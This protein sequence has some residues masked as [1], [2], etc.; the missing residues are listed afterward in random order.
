MKGGGGVAVAVAAVA[1]KR[2][3]GLVIGVLALVVLSML[4]PLI[5]LLGLYNGFHSSG[6]LFFS[7]LFASDLLSNF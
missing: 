3:R 4:V 7:P 1:K 2:W 5:F 6:R